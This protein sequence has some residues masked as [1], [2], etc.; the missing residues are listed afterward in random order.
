MFLFSLYRERQV[1]GSYYFFSLSDFYGICIDT[2]IINNLVSMT[3][4]LT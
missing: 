4:R 3:V 1:V 2:Y